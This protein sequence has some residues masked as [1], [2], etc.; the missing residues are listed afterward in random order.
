MVLLPEDYY[1][2]GALK[3]HV[4]NPCEVNNSTKFCLDYSYQEVTTHQGKVMVQ[5]ETGTP[6]SV[7]KISNPFIGVLLNELRV[8]WI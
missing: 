1:K 6:R 7:T 2:E 3:S 8:N 4:L 5:A